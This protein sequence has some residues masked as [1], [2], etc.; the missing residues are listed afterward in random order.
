MHPD[1]FGTFVDIA[2]DLSPN[3]GGQAQ[4]IDRLF[5]GNAA[6]WSAFDPSTVITR[7]GR[8]NNA[9]SGLFV[10]S[11]GRVDHNG[12]VAATANPEDDA[13]NTLCALGSARGIRCRW[14]PN[15]ASMI[16]LSP[17]EHSL[18]GVALARGP[19][20]HTR[21]ARAFRCHHQRRHRRS[22]RWPARGAY[23]RTTDSPPMRRSTPA[24]Q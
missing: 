18:R 17:A 20:Q 10:V 12:A 3:S 14:S 7:H 8:Y 4:T 2:G 21:R 1:Q 6:A 11:G 24:H 22:P 23:N 13:A 9:V 19:T 16:G 5:G 15:R